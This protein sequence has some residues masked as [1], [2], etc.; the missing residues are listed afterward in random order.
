MLLVMLLMV[1]FLVRNLSKGSSQF[2]GSS[3]LWLFSWSSLT[4]GLDGC[5]WGILMLGSLIV[6]M[7]NSE[8]RIVEF[9]ST[10]LKTIAVFSIIMIVDERGFLSDLSS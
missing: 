4:L 2:W 6:I 1:L 8:F 5:L 9:L 10:V 7:V 3:S